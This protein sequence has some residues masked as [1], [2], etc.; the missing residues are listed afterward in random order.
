MPAVLRGLLLLVCAAV[1]FGSKAINNDV[2]YVGR[3]DYSTGAARA[4]WPGTGIR[5]NLLT[6]KDKVTITVNYNNCGE[7]CNFYVEADLNCAAYQK[8]QIYS[9]TPSI[10]LSL[11]S[12]AG[13][14]L[15]VSFI[16]VTE[17]ANGNAVGVMEIGDIIVDGALF[18]SKSDVAN[19]KSVCARP[20]KM[21]VVG[22]SITAAYGGE[23]AMPCSF[24]ASTENSNIGYASVIAKTVGAE[25]HLAPWSGK[26]VVRNY[27]D[28]NQTSVDPMPA[29]YNRTIA[30]SPLGAN[31]FW[32]PSSYQPDVVLVTLGTN[33]YSTDPMASDSQFIIGLVDLLNLI[34]TDYPSSEVAALCA[35]M[36]RGN[37]CANIEAAANTVNAHY[38][39]IDPSTLS[40]GYGCDSHPNT[41]S[42]QN[43]ANYVLGYVQKMLKIKS[44]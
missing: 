17:S 5:M 7:S 35:P 29:F 4:D 42:Q 30:T 13:S 2:E 25:I 34:K 14:S 43:I 40:G 44:D 16:K 32:S 1:V 9:G 41:I 22:D 15:E 31:N 33:D 26:G 8:F 6:N 21:L 39:D 23:G 3:F 37:Q 38:V 36:R 12:T 20:Y 28:L 24:S 18:I 11:D 27:G 10:T 19:Y